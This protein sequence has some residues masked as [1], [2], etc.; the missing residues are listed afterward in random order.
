MTLF[1]RDPGT[2][3]EEEALDDADDVL[4]RSVAELFLS[5]SSSSATSLIRPEEE[6]E[7]EEE[8]DTAVVLPVDDMVRG[9]VRRSGQESGLLRGRS[10]SPSPFSSSSSSFSLSSSSLSSSLS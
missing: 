5:S 3:A 10:K 9:D 7:E 2:E 4:V 8:E 1:C 6:V